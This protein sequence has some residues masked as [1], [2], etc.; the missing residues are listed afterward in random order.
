MISGYALINHNSYSVFVFPHNAIN[1]GGEFCCFLSEGDAE[2]DFN[3]FASV[4]Y[5]ILFPHVI[6]RIIFERKDMKVDCREWMTKKKSRD[7]GINRIRTLCFCL[8]VHEE[9][10]HS[11]HRKELTFTMQ[12]KSPAC[13]IW[14]SLKWSVFHVIEGME[15]STVPRKKAERETNSV[16]RTDVLPA[17]LNRSAFCFFF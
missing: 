1:N 3:W 17:F 12:C 15:F 7:G 11:T 9:F 2:S 10:S 13:F 8:S 4:F 16:G 6:Y 5:F 14:L